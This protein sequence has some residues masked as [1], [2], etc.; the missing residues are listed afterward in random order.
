MYKIFGIVTELPQNFPSIH[1]L[2]RKCTFIYPLFSF[3][4][5]VAIWWP[6]GWWSKSTIAITSLRGHQWILTHVVNIP[7]VWLGHKWIL[8]H[9]VN[10]P[11]VLARKIFGSFFLFV[12]VTWFPC[13]L[14]SKVL[15]DI[16]MQVLV[17]KSTNNYVE[18]KTSLSQNT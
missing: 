2:K 4:C 3:F 5:H 13:K 15:M 1:S 6:N 12:M 10:I 16:R 7:R 17:L 18:E 9:I 14:S 11:T 8:T